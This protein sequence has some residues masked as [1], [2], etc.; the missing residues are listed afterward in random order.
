MGVPGV[1]RGGGPDRGEEEMKKTPA[2]IGDRI[3]VIKTCRQGCC[4]EEDFLGTVVGYERNGFYQILADQNLEE[5]RRAEFGSLGKSINLTKGAELDFHVQIQP[6]VGVEP[7]DEIDLE[8][9]LKI[10]KRA[11][12]DTSAPTPAPTPAP[13]P[14]PEFELC[15]FSLLEVD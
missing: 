13:A 7:D 1:E 3:H 15:R 8:E 11:C 6:Y 2:S 12:S 4:I 14:S 9:A 10:H 5:V